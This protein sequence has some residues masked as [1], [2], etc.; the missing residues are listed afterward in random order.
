MNR[1]DIFIIILPTNISFLVVHQLQTL[2]RMKVS[3]LFPRHEQPGSLSVRSGTGLTAPGAG[4]TTSRV[5][6]GLLGA[7]LSSAVALRKDENIS[8]I[9]RASPHAQSF[10]LSLPTCFLLWNK[11]MYIY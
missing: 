1:T 9:A 4:C 11:V 3:E 2:Q 10:A 6:G 5:G 7:L 8:I